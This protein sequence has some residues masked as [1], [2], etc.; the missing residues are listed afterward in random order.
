MTGKIQKGWPEAAALLMLFLLPSWS[1]SASLAQLQS[2]KHI[3]ISAQL[4]PFTDIVVGQRTELVIYIATDRWFTGGTRLEIPEVDGLVI[5]QTNN[6]ASN[7]SENRKG[8]SWVVQRWSLDVFPQRSGTFTIPPIDV[9]LSINDETAGDVKGTLRS[10]S[11]KF[12]A[13]VPEALSKTQHWVASPDYKVSQSFDRELTGLKAGDAIERTIVFEATGVM[14]M[15]LPGWQPENL[16]GLAVYPQPPSLTNNNNRGGMIAKRVENITYIAEESGQY[17]LPARD[18]Y[19]WDTSKGELQIRFLPAVD[20][21]VGEAAEKNINKD[22]SKILANVNPRNLL[23]YSALLAVFIALCWFIYKRLPRIS[24]A[25]ITGPTKRAWQR[26]NRMRKPA[27]PST[28]NPD[29]NAGE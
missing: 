21:A 26:L 25:Q 22:R 2:E 4:I 29:S 15:M 14:A 16:S 3:E 10:P 20:I 7:S 27:L 11:L 23:I 9:R 5:I 1:W 28:L 17:Q 13:S 8:Q 18:Y 6:F 24:L 19:W 12:Q